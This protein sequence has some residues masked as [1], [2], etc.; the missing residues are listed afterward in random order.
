MPDTVVFQTQA[1]TLA[2][3]AYESFIVSD[4]YSPVC[5]QS[6][7]FRVHSFLPLLQIAIQQFAN[8]L[9][10]TNTNASISILI[11]SLK[12][13]VP[14]LRRSNQLILFFAYL[15]IRFESFAYSFFISI[16]ILYD[17][18]DLR[19]L[20]VFTIDNNR[21]NMDFNEN[22]EGE[23]A[24]PP[25]I[26]TVSGRLASNR[27]MQHS[28]DCSSKNQARS[29]FIFIGT[30]VL[31]GTIEQWNCHSI[32]PSIAFMGTCVKYFTNY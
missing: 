26:F 6:P 27:M 16:Q 12:V 23:G 25:P 5:L 14:Q 22:W 13:C 31:Y 24:H 10:N 3:L 17:T 2:R 8:S 4:W 1:L 9:Y 11:C 19:L 28:D 29:I 30:L 18:D 21:K 32:R 20:F 7:T 15:E